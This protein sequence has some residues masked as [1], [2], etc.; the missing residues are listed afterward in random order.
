[1]PISHAELESGISERIGKPIRVTVAAMECLRALENAMPLTSWEL[2]LLDRL[3]QMAP[4]ARSQCHLLADFR[5]R[6]L[7]AMFTGRNKFTEYDWPET[8]SHPKVEE[9]QEGPNLPETLVWRLRLPQPS[10]IEGV[11]EM[12]LGERP[13]GG[14]AV[15]HMGTEPVSISDSVLPLF[16]LDDL[17]YLL[18]RTLYAGSRIS[19][20]GIALLI[21]GGRSES[22]MH[23]GKYNRWFLDSF[24]GIGFETGDPPSAEH[25]PQQSS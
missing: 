25:E 11:L 1:M 15:I 3:L 24:E 20:T 12:L 10:S 8:A 19:D 21:L 23:L 7:L 18:F 13:T 4:Q 9:I 22:E 2:W 5:Y 14:V 16:G 17:L 6:D